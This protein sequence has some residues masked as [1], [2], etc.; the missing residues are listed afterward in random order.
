MLILYD[1]GYAEQDKRNVL[2]VHVTQAGIP[3]RFII[4][5]KALNNGVVDLMM[6]VIPT[7][8]TKDFVG[9]GIEIIDPW[10]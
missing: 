1:F 5:M 2:C 3:L 4:K 7:R 6:A 10:E 9:C 8:N